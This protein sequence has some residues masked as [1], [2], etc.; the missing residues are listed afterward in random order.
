MK[1]EASSH[2]ILQCIVCRVFGSGEKVFGSRYCIN[3]TSNMLV[4]LLCQVGINLA[5]LSLSPPHLSH[6]SQPPSS[7]LSLLTASLFPPLTS[8]LLLTASLLTSLTSHSLPLPASHFYYSSLH[9]LSHPLPSLPQLED[10]LKRLIEH[11]VTVTTDPNTLFRGNTIVTKMVDEFMKLIG[12]SYLRQTLQCC[13]DE[14]G[15]ACS[16]LVYY[17]QYVLVTFEPRSLSL[18]SRVK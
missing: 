11:E 14:V 9:P 17:I 8:S 10:V 1:G 12:L 15:G 3:V 18:E 6:F 2:N 4:S 13:I 16:L 7:R 5:S